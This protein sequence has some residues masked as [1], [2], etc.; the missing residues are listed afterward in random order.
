[1]SVDVVFVGAGVNSLAAAFLLGR[2]GLSVA[3][4]EANDEPGGAIRTADVTLPGFRHDLGAMNLGA[5]VRSPFYAEHHQ[6]LADHGF[7]AVVADQSFGSVFAAGEFLGIGTDRRA[8]LDA[9]AEVAPGDA[10]AWR[11]WSEDFDACAPILGEILQ[12]PAGSGGPL[13]HLSG[14]GVDIPEDVRQT[15]RGILVDSLRANLTRRFASDEV[16]VLVGAW[17]LHLDYAPDVAGGCWMPF[18]ETNADERNGISIARGG[19]ARLIEAMV[20]A[21]RSTGGELRTRAPVDRIVVRHGRAVGVRLV[22]GNEVGASRAV[23]ASVTPPALARLTDGSLPAPAA[24][25][26][27]GW[28]FGP[29][30]LVIHL[31][32]SGPVEWSAS[33]DAGQS[34]YVHIGPSLDHLATV[35]EQGLAGTLAAE[36]FCVVAQ[37][38]VHDPSR[39][40]GGRDVLWIMVRAVPAVI[41]GDVLDQITGP[42]WTDTAKDV[43]ANRVV[44]LLERHA[45]GLGGRILA[46]RVFA[47]PDLERLNPNLVDGDLNAGSMHLDQFYGE[48]PFGDGSRS[49]LPGLY[50]CGAATWPGGGTQP[51][52]GMLV[53]D[54]LR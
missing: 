48:R 23:V 24:A 29:G 30:T 39:A 2:A 34:F 32:L 43:F 44:G 12:S 47:P 14:R 50:V 26:A 6:E 4:L 17:G 38:T 40:P 21:V 3:V 5:F 8:N 31:A 49:P 51:T 11:R 20:G 1:M 19:S 16:R 18:L 53:A 45:P 54:L 41:Q 37:P 35:Y 27:R 46:R 52:S 10:A 9:I 28:R 25:Q 7:E 33:Q 22:D 42:Q 13:A 15:L 36:P